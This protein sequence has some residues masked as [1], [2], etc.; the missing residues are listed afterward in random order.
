MAPH[1]YLSSGGLGLFCGF[2]RPSTHPKNRQGLLLSCT[3]LTRMYTNVHAQLCTCTHTHG[4]SVACVYTYMCVQSH[5]CTHT[6]TNRCTDVHLHRYTCVHHCTH[7]HIYMCVHA[8]TCSAGVYVCTHAYIP[9]YTHRQSPG[10]ASKSSRA[11]PP[12]DSGQHV[13]P[14]GTQTTFPIWGLPSQPRTRCRER[15]PRNLP[16]QLPALLSQ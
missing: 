5:V 2:P 12:H 4:C 10:A 13:S 8:H 6:C 3:T 16:C 14:H 9:V 1:R 7:V 15:E 11:T